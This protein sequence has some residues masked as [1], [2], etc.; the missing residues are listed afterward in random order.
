MT[1]ALDMIPALGARVLVRCD[2]SREAMQVE[3]T[4]KNVKNSWGKPRLLVTPVA[5]SGE[6][7]VELERVTVPA[8]SD[9]R[10]LTTR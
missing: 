4:V 7:W 3:C 5:G 8:G 2:A 6:Q 10:R 9:E 1:T